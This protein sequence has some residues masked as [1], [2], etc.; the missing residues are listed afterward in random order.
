MRRERRPPS[1]RAG[2]RRGGRRRRRRRPPRRARRA[3][4]WEWIRSAGTRGVRWTC[5]SPQGL[6]RAA[7]AI[8][9]TAWTPRR[10]PSLIASAVAID[11][12][13]ARKVVGGA[14]FAWST[15]TTRKPRELGSTGVRRGAAIFGQRSRIRLTA[16]AAA[17][18]ASWSL[19]WAR[20]PKA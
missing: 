17:W 2:R 11:V 4:L 18:R 15:Q 8:G 10:K 12:S 20:R 13:P 16:L 1:R 5:Q 7:A 3:L 14:S 6:L 19:S 9:R